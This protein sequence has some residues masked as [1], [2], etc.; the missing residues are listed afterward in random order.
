[1]K[2]FQSWLYGY[3]LKSPDGSFGAIGALICY[4]QTKLITKLNGVIQVN[5]R[6]AAL[7]KSFCRNQSAIQ[8][9]NM[10][11]IITFHFIDSF[12]LSSGCFKNMFGDMPTH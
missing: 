6:I 11:S 2:D 10:A 1:M 12:N 8:C 4:Q 9:L 5:Q 7:I 3:L